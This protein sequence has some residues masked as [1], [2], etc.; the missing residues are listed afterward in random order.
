MFN[1]IEMHRKQLTV[2]WTSKVIVRKNK[3][4]LI[5]LDLW[6]LVRAGQEKPITQ[7]LEIIHFFFNE[8]SG[9]TI[10]TSKTFSNTLETV[11]IFNY[12]LQK[13]SSLN[14]NMMFQM[15]SKI[16]LNCDSVNI[17]IQLHDRKAQNFTFRNSRIRYY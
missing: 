11:W 7:I 5:I 9:K 4:S 13:K 2:Y 17:S 6:I 12:Y 3:T 10:I 15:H 8:L 1:I 16:V 14:S